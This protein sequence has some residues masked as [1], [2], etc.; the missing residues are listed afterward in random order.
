MRSRFTHVYTLTLF[1]S[2]S[3]PPSLCMWLILFAHPTPSPLSLSLALS[4]SLSPSLS[5]QPTLQCLCRQLHVC[6]EMTFQQHFTFPYFSL[7]ILILDSLCLLLLSLPNS[8]ED[9]DFLCF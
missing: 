5:L 9:T 7:C 6:S 1:I 8:F 3:L 2:L 4:L